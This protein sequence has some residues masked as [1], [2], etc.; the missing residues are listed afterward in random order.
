[1]WLKTLYLM[2]VIPIS[3]HCNMDLN[4]KSELGDMILKSNIL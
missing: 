3:F 1:M 4:W 2:F